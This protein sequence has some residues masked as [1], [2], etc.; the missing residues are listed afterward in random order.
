M[1]EDGADNAPDVTINDEEFKEVST[2]E[3]DTEVQNNSLVN[4]ITEKKKKKTRRG[5]SKKRILKNHKIIYNNIRGYA[6]KEKSVKF[7][8]K[9]EQPALLILLETFLKDGDNID[10]EFYEDNNY[11]SI[12]WERKAWWWNVN[13]DEEETKKYYNNTKNRR[14]NTRGMLDSNG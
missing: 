12:R 13:Y 1:G 6:K 11:E 4:K 8:V 5:G 9:E 10:E 14:K 7:V 2:V 3:N